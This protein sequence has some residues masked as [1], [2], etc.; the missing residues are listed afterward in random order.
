MTNTHVNKA[1]VAPY[2]RIWNRSFFIFKRRNLWLS[3]FIFTILTLHIPQEKKNRLFTWILLV[4]ICTL[5]WYL[6]F[7]LSYKW[8]LMFLLL[9]GGSHLRFLDWLAIL[10][11]ILGSYNE[12]S[13]FLFFIWKKKKTERRKYFVYLCFS[14]V[15]IHFSSYLCWGSIPH[16]SSLFILWSNHLGY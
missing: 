9:I 12:C 13:F 4:Y 15:Y 16:Q 5:R 14:H 8:M 6:K 1:K 2:W 10:I 3:F 11:Y 7:L